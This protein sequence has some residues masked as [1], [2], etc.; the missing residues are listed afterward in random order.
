MIQLSLIDT[1]KM[2]ALLD[3]VTTVKDVPN[4]RDIFINEG[5]IVFGNR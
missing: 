5:E 3:E 2:F 1:E 4:A